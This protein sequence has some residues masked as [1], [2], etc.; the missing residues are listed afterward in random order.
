MVALV[1]AKTTTTYTRIVMSDTYVACRTK[2]RLATGAYRLAEMLDADWS[3]VLSVGGAS[4]IWRKV[5]YQYIIHQFRWTPHL[6][7]I[8]RLNITSKEKTYVL[9]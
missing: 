2:W 1:Y 4:L 6:D 3:V 7:D 8:N 5:N 9:L